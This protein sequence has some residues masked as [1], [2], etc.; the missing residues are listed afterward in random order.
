[1]TSRLNGIHR[2]PAETFVPARGS[3]SFVLGLLACFLSLFLPVFV[4]GFNVEDSCFVGYREVG[5][6]P[7][8][9]LHGQ[10]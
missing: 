3:F 4:H 6:I 8:E 7:E 1:M 2:Q 10:V 5:C 9:Q